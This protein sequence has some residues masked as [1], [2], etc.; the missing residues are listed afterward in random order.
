MMCRQMARP[1]P[2]LPLASL[3]SFSTR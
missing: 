1:S 2:V 3:R